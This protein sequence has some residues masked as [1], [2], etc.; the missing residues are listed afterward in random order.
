MLSGNS[1]NLILRNSL[2]SDAHGQAHNQTH[3]QARDRIY[4]RLAQQ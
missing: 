4:K 1:T 3:D 2:I